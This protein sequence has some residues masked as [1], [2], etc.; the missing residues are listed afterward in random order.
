MSKK[1]VYCFPGL[2]ASPKI[3][4]YISLPKEKFEVHRLEWKLPLS[5]EES[6]ES[7]AERI[8][9]DIHHDKPILLG[10]SFGGMIVQEI[11][12]L[13][14]IEKLVIVSSLKSH[15]EL[16]KRLRLIR[17]SK[18]YK[19]FPARIAENLEEYTK[20]FFGD[21]L[22]KRAEL[23]KMYLS[24]RDADYLNWAIYNVLHWKQDT[25]PKDIIH[26]HGTSDHVF[27]HKSIKDFIP[28]ENG[29]HEMILTKGKKVSSILE[30][31]L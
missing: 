10:V 14:E 3:F 11:A 12:K 17:D 23:Y 13:I 15:H 9:E 5:L 21:F 7:Y 19:L 4:E 18:V 25:A 1:H 30:E 24:V 22:K 29:A 16:P 27:P 2:G 20:Y 26:I 31:V 6:L 8:C 28:V